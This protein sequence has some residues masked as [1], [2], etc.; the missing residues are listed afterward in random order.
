MGVSMVHI[1]VVSSEGSHI[2]VEGSFSLKHIRK[3]VSSTHTN[4]SGLGDS[5]VCW[6]ADLSGGDKKID[7]L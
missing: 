6:S 3:L 7:M 4:S 2:R 1:T 5:R